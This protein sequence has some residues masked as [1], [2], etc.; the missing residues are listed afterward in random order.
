MSDDKQMLSQTTN[1]D[2][3]KFFRAARGW[4]FQAAN[5]NPDEDISIGS[6][7]WMYQAFKARMEAEREQN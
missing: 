3:E 4:V 7:E 6:M 2:Y 5:V 1:I